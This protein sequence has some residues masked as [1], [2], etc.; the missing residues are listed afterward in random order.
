MSPGSVERMRVLVVD[1]NADLVD[2][3]AEFLEREHDGITAVTATSAD[4]AL[5]RLQAE[6]VDCVVSDYDMPETNG[7]ELLRDIRERDPDLPFVLFTGKGSEEIASEAISAGV[8]EYLQKGTATEQYTVLANRVERA[9]SEHRA[10]TRQAETERRF[11]TLVENLP[12]M[13]YR[14]RNEPDWPMEFVS[15]GCKELTGYT[16]GEIESGTVNWGEEVI[17]PEDREDMWDAVQQVLNGEETFQ[18]TYRI[19]RADGEIRWCW[20]RGQMVTDS[21]ND[22]ILE[23][24]IT[25]ITPRKRREQELQ[26]EREFTE[27]ALNALDDMF[28]VIDPATEKLIRWNDRVPEQTGY[29]ERELATMKGT[30]IIAADDRDRAREAMATAMTAGTVTIETEIVSSTGERIPYEFRGTVISDE[31]TD[32]RGIATVGRDVS[33]QREREQTLERYRTLVENV[34]DPM[35]V[36]NPDGTIEMVNRAMGDH[37]GYDPEELVGE[38]ASFF[39][40]GENSDRGSEIIASLIESDEKEWETWEMQVETRDGTVTSHENKVAILTAE[41]GSF[42]GSVGVV[43]DIT[44]RK[45]REEELERYETVVQAVGDPVYALDDDG[46]ITFVNDAAE[47]MTGYD[48]DSLVGSHIDKILADD[49][50]DVGRTQI[51]ELL[52]D[53]NRRATT[54]EVNVETR[55]GDRIPSEVHIALLPTPDDTFQ[56]TAGIIRDIEQRKEREE[57]LE[58][59]ASVVSHDLRG[60]LNVI[61]GRVALARQHTDSDELDAIAEAAARMEGLIEDLLTLAR[62]GQT[63]GDSK[64]VALSS[65][66]ENAW[67]SVETP[68]ATLKNQATLSIKADPERLQELLENLFRNAVEHGDDGVRITVDK[69]DGADGFYVADDGPGIP[70]DEREAVF[71]HG[72]TTNEHGTGFG[73]SIV[74]RIADAHGWSVSVT[75]SEDGG[76]RFEI[77]TG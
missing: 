4:E 48:A 59:F 5:D 40:L 36:L 65:V 20:E 39:L 54:F 10:R 71:D 12:G 67:Q 13:A 47:A 66:I 3:V 22:E 30:E 72:Y 26:A 35:Y 25:D 69:L 61:L 41:D 29:A 60:P 32:R 57:R 15:D 31:G 70:E 75:E 19:R 74:E 21:Q 27:S 7:L 44:E 24:F 6:S 11:A 42:V 45:Q 23:G 58:Q 46:V 76:A 52:G 16:T 68:P 17:H 18:V 1:D 14:C 28:F 49:G 53:P 55:D 51:R 8:T 9:V 33:E 43:R 62:Q 37:L 50:V 63:I 56:G 73:L 64:Q 38:P 77:R 34:G 2:I